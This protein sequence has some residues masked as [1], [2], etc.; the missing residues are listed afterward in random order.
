MIREI[1]PVRGPELGLVEGIKKLMGL[2]FAD[3]EAKVGFKYPDG[4][5]DLSLADKINILR[6]VQEALMNARKHARASKVLVE[7]LRSGDKNIEVTVRDKEAGFEVAEVLQQVAGHYGLLAMQE[8]AKLI[9]GQL[10]IES[11]PGEGT[12]IRGISPI[13]KARHFSLAI[14][15]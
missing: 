3:R 9:N 6:I 8:R 1:E 5:S 2:N 15:S 7:I 11:K 13:K 14:F 4:L 12:V 10:F